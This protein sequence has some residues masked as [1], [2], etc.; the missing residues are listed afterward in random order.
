MELYLKAALAQAAVPARER[1]G[2]DLK[3]LFAS[4]EMRGLLAFPHQGLLR[5]I[6]DLLQHD[7]KTYSFRYMKPESAVTV[8][9]DVDQSLHILQSL[10]EHLRPR[11][12]L[13]AA[14]KHSG[15]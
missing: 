5:Q 6:V 10:D 12:N 7:H 8:I 13:K 14:R 9:Y 3:A 11:V 2:H 15:G 4:A 1:H